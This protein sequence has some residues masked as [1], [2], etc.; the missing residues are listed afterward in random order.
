[1]SAIRRFA[2]AYDTGDAITEG[3]GTS[4]GTL[5]AHSLRP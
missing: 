4:P 5:P 1:M 3:E 2:A